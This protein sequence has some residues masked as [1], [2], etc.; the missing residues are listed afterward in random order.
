VAV[1]PTAAADLIWEVDPTA[2]ADRIAAPVQIAEAV[3]SAVVADLISVAVQIAAALRSVE[4]DQSVVAD[5]T[6]A[7]NEVQ[8]VAQ[9]VARN[10]VPIVQSGQLYPD[11]KVSLV[12][13]PRVRTAVHLPA[14][15]MVDAMSRFARA[16]LENASRHHLPAA[17]AEQPL[18]VDCQVC[19]L[20]IDRLR[21][22]A[23]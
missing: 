14:A 22:D 2:A 7:L 3:P 8:N 19:L 17:L 9:I 11:A 15:E 10:E 1:D 13:R 21:A 4:V 16:D 18:P 6:A 12:A 20:A 5:P 23:P